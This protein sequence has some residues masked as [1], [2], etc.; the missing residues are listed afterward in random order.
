MEYWPYCC[1]VVVVWVRDGVVFYVLV[2]V[3]FHF[4]ISAYVCSVKMKYATAWKHK[5]LF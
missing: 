5:Q 3:V 1:C 2:V 4:E